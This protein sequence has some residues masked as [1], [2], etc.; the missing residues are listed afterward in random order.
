MSCT[1]DQ[2]VSGAWCRHQ[3]T[4]SLLRARSQTLSGL[5]GPSAC[6]QPRHSGGTTQRHR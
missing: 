4:T 3:R 5:R 2:N 6:K 1:A